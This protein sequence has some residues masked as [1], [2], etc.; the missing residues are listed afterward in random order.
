MSKAAK[1]NINKILN[2][3]EAI[4]EWFES[5]EVDINL[6]LKKYELGLAKIKQL[7]GYLKSAKVEVEKINKRFDV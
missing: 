4:V 5:E 1:P 6:A 7:E 3:V 2:E